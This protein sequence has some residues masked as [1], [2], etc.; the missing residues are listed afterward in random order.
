[1]SGAL[2]EPDVGLDASTGGQQNAAIPPAMRCLHSA[3]PDR[4]R[5]SGLGRGCVALVHVIFEAAGA[6]IQ[7]G[8]GPRIASAS[9][10]HPSLS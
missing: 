7:I 1:V 4:A 8:D 5:S 2:H 3:Q 9:E 6:V 10:L